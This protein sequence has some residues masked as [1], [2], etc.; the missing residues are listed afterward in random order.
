[1]IVE[2][3]V[4]ITLMIFAAVATRLLERVRLFK[5]AYQIRKLAEKYNDEDRKRLEKLADKLNEL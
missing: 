2:I 5:A 1:M 4:A 3:I